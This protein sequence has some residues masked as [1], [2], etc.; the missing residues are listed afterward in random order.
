MPNFENRTLFHGENLDILR[1]IDSE[2]ID[3]I[4][5]DPPFNKGRDFHA[6]PDS[7]ASGAKFQDRWD[8]DR[9]T[10][11][12]WHDQIKDE[13][14]AVW[15]AIDFAK[16]TYGEDMGAFLCFMGVRLMEMHRV[17]KPTGSLY[18]HCDPTA[19]HYLKAMCDAVFG[20]RQFRNEIVWRKYSGRKNNAK[21]KFS[22]Q[23]ETLLF[24]GKTS[25][26][27]FNMIIIPH[28]EEE[29]R[30]KYTHVDDDG[31]KYR[32]AWGRTY[33]QTGEN[34]RIYLDESPGRAVGNL[35]TEDGLQLNTSSSERTGY[36]TQKPLSL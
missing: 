4:A 21:R 19:S 34:R 30:K 33:Q 25:R 36:P 32:L 24:Y 35:W 27:A 22:T 5:T 31:R 7:L 10:E 2:T 3:L 16:N 18:L 20:R 13:S 29:I 26:S 1:G 12:A 17:L 28:S 8:W 11:G 23:H 6:T 9:D 14:S 15:G